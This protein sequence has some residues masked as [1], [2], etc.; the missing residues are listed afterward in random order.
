MTLIEELALVLYGQ[1][2]DDN[3]M[4]SELELI[5]AMLQQAYDEGRK[6]QP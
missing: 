1:L 2:H 6:G 4:A 5:E 3:R